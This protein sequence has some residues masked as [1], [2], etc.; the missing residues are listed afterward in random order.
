MNHLNA[1]DEKLT[2]LFDKLTNPQQQQQQQPVQYVY[3]YSGQPTP[4]PPGGLMPF[5]GTPAVVTT[6]P[7][8]PGYRPQYPQP[9]YP[10]VQTVHMSPQSSFSSLQ[11]AQPMPVVMAPSNPSPLP[12]GWIQQWS[13]QYQRVYYVEV[14]TNR[15]LW[16]LPVSS[17]PPTSAAPSL[18][19][20]SP[21]SVPDQMLSPPANEIQT[22]FTA[23]TPLVRQPQ[24]SVEAN[25]SVSNF[26]EKSAGAAIPA[27]GGTYYTTEAGVKPSDPSGTSREKKLPYAIPSI[28]GSN[29]TGL[30][31]MKLVSDNPVPVSSASQEA[32]PPYSLLD[33]RVQN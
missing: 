19:P 31:P 32:P 4:V 7:G 15:S 23:N 30:R 28:L 29:S 17:H 3:H 11:A 25:T 9:A 26:P 6:A 24:P 2:A 13:P 18:Q 16:E 10:Q 20:F 21:T 1:L 5:A 8:F 27:T 14:S 22:V 33:E 12:P